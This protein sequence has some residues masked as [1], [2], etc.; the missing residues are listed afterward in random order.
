M[1]HTHKRIQNRHISDA[2]KATLRSASKQCRVPENFRGMGPETVASLIAT[3]KITRDRACTEKK[4][5]H[6]YGYATEVRDAMLRKHGHTQE[7][8]ACPF[9]SGYHLATIDEV[10]R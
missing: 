10:T 2:V 4:R 5:Y 3:G 8:Y 6:T 1:R 9:C 7:V